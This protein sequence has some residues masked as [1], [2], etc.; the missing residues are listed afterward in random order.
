M[1][2]TF[3]SYKEL[4][5]S[6]GVSL[7]PMG[8]RGRGLNRYWALEALKHLEGARVPIAGGQVLEVLGKSSIPSYTLDTWDVEMAPNES[9]EDYCAR[10]LAEARNFITHY[11]EPSDRETL[12]EIVLDWGKD[13]YLM[14]PE[15]TT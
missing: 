3:E 14:G 5:N 10:S 2:M 1:A 6:Q 7:L 15:E 8:V 12:Y 9:F 11:R 13:M 4:Y